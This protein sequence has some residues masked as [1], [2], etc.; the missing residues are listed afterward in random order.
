MYTN[1]VR[2]ELR[3]AVVKQFILTLNNARSVPSMP[4]GPPNYDVLGTLY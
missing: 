3:P 2:R 1:G 4:E